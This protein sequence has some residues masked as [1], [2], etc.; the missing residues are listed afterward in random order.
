MAAAKRKRFGIE[1]TA[2]ELHSR[3]VALKAEIGPEAWVQIAV[4]DGRSDKP[5]RGTIYAFGIGKQSGP[6]FACEADTFAEVIDS[7]V[8]GWAGFQVEHARR[9]TAD[10]ALEII[11]ITDEM[12]ECSDAALRGAK[13]S[14]GD[15]IRFGV[16]ACAK[17]NEMAGRGPFSIVTIAGANGRAA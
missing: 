10:L 11:R 7:L 3:V 17:A 13:F 8:N 12:G 16:A 4:N 9:V 15:V 14:V 5:L 1:L 6:S 2:R